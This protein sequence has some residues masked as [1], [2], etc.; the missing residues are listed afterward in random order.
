MDY[1]NH[2]FLAKKKKRKKKKGEKEHHENKI[3]LEFNSHNLTSAKNGISNI[4]G[5]VL[6]AL[7][8]SKTPCNLIAQIF[9]NSIKYVYSITAFNRYHN[10]YF[11]GKDET[12]ILLLMQTYQIFLY[13]LNS[14]TFM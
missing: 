12:S 13:A 5:N 2:L 8:F 1:Q 4:V 6:I 7:N 9:L 3:V 11:L 10:Q 14:I